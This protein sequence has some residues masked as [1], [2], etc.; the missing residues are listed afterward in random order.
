MVCSNDLNYRSNDF[1]IS[2]VTNFSSTE[3]NVDYEFPVLYEACIIYKIA[4]LTMCKT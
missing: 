3:Y 1:F 4:K 2:K